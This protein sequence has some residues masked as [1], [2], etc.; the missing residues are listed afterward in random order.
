MGTATVIM[1]NF[2]FLRQSNTRNLQVLALENGLS[3]ISINYFLGIV[4][5][6]VWRINPKAL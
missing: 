2:F 6:I 5:S 1:V 4:K 3:I